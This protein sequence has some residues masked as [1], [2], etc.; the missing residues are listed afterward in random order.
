MAHLLD[1]LSANPKRVWQ[2]RGLGALAL[3]VLVAAGPVYVHLAHPS[4]E[5]CHGGEKK[6]SS[7]WNDS[8]QEAIS[9]AF[10]SSEKPY[11][12]DAWRSTKKT[13]DEYARAW[14]VMHTDACQATQRGEQSAALL[15][16][17]MGMPR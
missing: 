6:L 4:G 1:T 3:S 13:L 2:Q 15:D 12:A 14:V 9:R 10:L 16:R 7:V 11:A 5:V 17:R 8:R